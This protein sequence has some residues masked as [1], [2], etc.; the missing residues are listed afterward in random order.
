MKTLFGK[1]LGSLLGLSLALCL[2]FA[3]LSV[4][5]IGQI[6]TEIND[7]ALAETARLLSAYLP[8]PADAAEL[9]RWAR[10]AGGASSYRVTIVTSDGR[11]AAD[12][13][14]DP[15][16]MENHGDRPEIIQAL[17]GFQA[18]ATRKSNTLGMEQRYIALPIKDGEGKIIAAFRLSLDTPAMESRLS[19]LQFLLVTVIA[20]AAALAALV[21]VFLSRGIT[22][23]LGLLAAAAESVPR[24]ERDAPGSRAGGRFELK[25]R[26]QLARSSREIRVLG[27]ALDSMAGELS[28]RAESA[29]AKEREVEAILDGVSEAVLALDAH[30]NLRLAN[31]AARQFFDFP[32]ASDAGRKTKPC[33]LEISRSPA[34]E[35]VAQKALESSSAAEVDIELYRQGSQRSFRVLAAAYGMQS[36]SREPEGVVLVLND[37]T[38]LRRLETIRRDFVA[39]VS[40]ELRTPVQL[41]KGFAET[42]LGGALEDPDKARRFSEIIGRN[43]ARMERL[44]D[45]LLSLAKLEQQE[46]ES[47]ETKSESLRELVLEAIASVEYAAMGKN[48]KLEL[49][50]PEDIRVE[51]NGGLIVQAVF[52]LLD[53]AVK[54]SPAESQVRIR[55]RRIDSRLRIEVRDQGPGIPAAQLPRLFER[56]YRVDKARSREQ[57]GTGLGLAIV[58]H[59]AE[60]HGGSVGVESWEG[61]GSLFWIELDANA[62]A[63]L[64]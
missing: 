15:A 16:T 37:L 32:Q 13:K 34:L 5:L 49:D 57:G 1:T 8:D 9:R 23:P 6:H 48:L 56:F 63:R 19:E 42:L 11:V 35:E 51:V 40:H 17:S 29:E 43:A 14:A 4:T 64:G 38:V 20:F 54:Y 41:V 18:R 2:V 36:G 24:G 61:E 47:L 46:R 55:A 12:S 22:R 7:K 44:I 21:A 10:E 59:I 53:N 25:D 45:D 28:L 27:E 26:R 62:G 52:N 60:V 30:L 33:L 50:C 39:N 31:K 58:R 3:L